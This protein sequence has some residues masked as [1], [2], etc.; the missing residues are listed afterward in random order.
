MIWALDDQVTARA[1]VV[2]RPHSAGEV[3]AV[4]RLCNE[5]AFP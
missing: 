3:A 5:R 1:A 2:A 4:L